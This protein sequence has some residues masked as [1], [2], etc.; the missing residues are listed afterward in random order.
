MRPTYRDV[1]LGLLWNTQRRTV[2]I[3]EPKIEKARNRVTAMLKRGRATKTEFYKLLGSLRH[4]ANCLRTAKPFYQ[5]LQKQ[6]TSAPRFGLT[7]LSAGSRAN[8]QWFRHILDYGCLAELPHCM[9]GA[10]P[11]PD[12]ELYM[13]ASNHG[14]AVLDPACDSFLQVRFD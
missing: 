7:K 4:V 3:P 13:D 11:S 8:L 2:S 6:C 12:V 9:F 14:L 1:V 5:Q 10:L